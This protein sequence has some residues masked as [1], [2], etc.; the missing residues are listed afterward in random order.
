MSSM[1]LINYEGPCTWCGQ[2]II[3]VPTGDHTNRAG[4]PAYRFTHAGS[5]E[6]IYGN[7]DLNLDVVSARLHE[8]MD[9]DD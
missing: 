2:R 8:R 1:S 4:R 9:E 6:S 7:A 5:L 3:W